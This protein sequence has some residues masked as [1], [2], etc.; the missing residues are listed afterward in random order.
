[1]CAL[2]SRALSLQLIEKAGEDAYGTWASLFIHSMDILFKS[3]DW[4]SMGGK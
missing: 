3:Y 1:M 4:S 2:A